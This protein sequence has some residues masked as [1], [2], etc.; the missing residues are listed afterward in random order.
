MQLASSVAGVFAV[1]EYN[2]ADSGTSPDK[3]EIDDL[4]VSLK[5]LLELV[6]GDAS[7]EIRNFHAVSLEGG[8]V[9]IDVS[10]D[11]ARSGARPASTF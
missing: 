6:F 5:L 10:D 3:N 8:I 2:K 7:V 4:S 11:R 9:A 1:F